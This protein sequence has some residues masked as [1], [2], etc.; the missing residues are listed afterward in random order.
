RQWPGENRA[1]II[2]PFS[3][4]CIAC[5]SVTVC[6]S[7]VAYCVSNGS[8]KL[9]RALSL[10]P[11]CK[12]GSC[13]KAKPGNF[14]KHASGIFSCLQGLSQLVAMVSRS[15]HLCDRLGEEH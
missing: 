15:Q 3:A 7:R 12:L 9:G 8:A 14:G 6:F 2:S 11:I 13:M 1:R 4:H 5:A 10:H